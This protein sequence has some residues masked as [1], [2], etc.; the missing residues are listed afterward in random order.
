MSR[1]GYRLP[2]CRNDLYG[3]VVRGGG[4]AKASGTSTHYPEKTD[5]NKSRPKK[6]IRI[7][8]D[9]IVKGSSQGLGGGGGVLRRSFFWEKKP[10]GPSGTRRHRAL[11]ASK[12]KRALGDATAL[13]T[14]SC[15]LRRV[16][17]RGG[18]QREKTY[19][20]EASGRLAECAG[21]L[22]TRI[23]MQEGESNGDGERKQKGV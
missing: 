9:L 12:I 13:G 3:T 19:H 5:E 14:S 6:G 20:N 4:L 15:G 10:L 17:G 2:R 1:K 11:H 18:A 23:N 16:G 21:G 7:R 22:I 8:D